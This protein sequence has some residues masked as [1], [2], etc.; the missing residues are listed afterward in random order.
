[1]AL[2]YKYT[3]EPD[4]EGVLV[5]PY[6]PDDRGGRTN[7]GFVD[8]RGNPEQAF[9]IAEAVP[10]QALKALLVALAAP[11]SSFFSVGCTLGAH[12]LEAGSYSAGGYIQVA[13]TDLWRKASHCPNHSELS[14][15]LKDYLD[16][17]VGER[18]WQVEFILSVIGTAALGGPDQVW[19]P[20]IYFSSSASTLADAGAS[21]EE[22]IGALTCFLTAE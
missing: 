7:R 3:L 9:Q 8:L 6:P 22:L 12:R 2:H 19:S 11:G 4:E 5:L 17:N 13:Y 21:T 15:R 18:E 20:V 1:M 14:N 10:S 16:L